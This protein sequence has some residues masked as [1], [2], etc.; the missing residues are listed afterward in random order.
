MQF[1]SQC[2]KEVQ[3][4]IAAPGDDVLEL[5]HSPLRFHDGHI[6]LFIRSWSNTSSLWSIISHYNVSRGRHVLITSDSIQE[7]HVFITFVYK[8]ESV[9]HIC[10]FH[11]CGQSLPPFLLQCPE[12]RILLLAPILSAL[13]YPLIFWFLLGSLL[14]RNI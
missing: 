7:K 3:N 11:V 1:V 8:Y 12:P 2:A 14:Y 9:S 13:I 4:F 5:F 6:V 10:A